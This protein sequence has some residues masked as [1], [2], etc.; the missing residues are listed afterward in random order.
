MLLDAQRSILI[1]IDLQQKLIPAI[2]KG[3][4]VV[5]NS[6]KLIEG[7]RRLGVPVIVSEQYP[8]GLGPTV[9]KIATKLPNETKIFAKLTFSAARSEDFAREINSLRVDGRDQMVLCGTETHICVM[10]TAA[11]LLAKDMLVYLVT[12]ASGSRTEEN[13]TAGAERLS[14]FGAQCVT[15][16][17][18]LFEWLEVAGSNEFK[19]ISKLIK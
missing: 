2:N 3:D 17:M 15:S 12:D 1:V 7:A 6:G 14:H 11:D 10:Q 13:Q 4:Q 9:E 8:K 18:V 5:E 16:E 19:E